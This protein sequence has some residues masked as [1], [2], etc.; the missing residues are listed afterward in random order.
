MSLDVWLTVKGEPIKRAGTGV[1]VRRNGKTVELSAKEVAEQFDGAEIQPQEYESN[2]V[3]DNN[4]T[5]NLTEMASKADLYTALWRPDEQGWTKAKDITGILE[6]GLKR[7]KKDP[8]GFKKY[9]PDNGWGS[10]DGLVNFTE[11][12]LQ[13]CKDY[14]EAEIGVS[15]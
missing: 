1:F 2:E 10:Y 3:Y 8:T 9:N 13:A 14:P 15:R 6:R 4:I 12:Y 5:H 7:L 11:S